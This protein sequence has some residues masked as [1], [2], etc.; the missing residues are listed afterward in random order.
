MVSEWP[1]CTPSERPHLEWIEWMEKDGWV[2]EWAE[3]GWVGEWVG[4]AESR[5]G[6]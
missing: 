5:V 6:G 2:V 4:W 1:A 3:V